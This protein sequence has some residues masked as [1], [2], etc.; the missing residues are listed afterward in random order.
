M[1]DAMSDSRPLF[2]VSNHHVESCG[3]PPHFDGDIRKRCHGYYENEYGEHAIFVHDY[4]ANEDT[5]WMGMPREKSH[6]KS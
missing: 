6:T 2:I 4:G 3:M 1:R 5:L